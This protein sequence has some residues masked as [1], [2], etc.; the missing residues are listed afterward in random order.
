ME[1]YV[2]YIFKNTQYLWGIFVGYL[3][4]VIFAFI[5]LFMAIIVYTFEKIYNFRIIYNKFLNNRTIKLLQDFGIFF[6]LLIVCF[7]L[8]IFIY[9]AIS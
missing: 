2:N 3:G 4:I 6:E 8:L 7:S 9:A 1:F 5:T